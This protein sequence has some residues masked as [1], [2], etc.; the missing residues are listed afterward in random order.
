VHQPNPYFSA[1]S[2]TDQDQAYPPLMSPFATYRTQAELNS[3][4]LSPQ[5]YSFAAPRSHLLAAHGTCANFYN[6]V[7][8]LTGTAVD[9]SGTPCAR[10]S[11]RF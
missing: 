1:M 9:P 11:P 7:C 5:R 4:P 2:R 10:F 6:G 3:L 8:A